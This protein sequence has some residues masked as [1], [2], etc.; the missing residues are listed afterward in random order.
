VYYADFSVTSAVMAM[1]VYGADKEYIE[2]PTEYFYQVWSC[3][4][5]QIFSAS[6]LNNL[7][8]IP[9]YFCR[10]S[11]IFSDDEEDNERY[12]YYS[13]LFSDMVYSSEEVWSENDDAMR[14]G[15]TVVAVFAATYAGEFDL[16]PR[17]V[18]SKLIKSAGVYYPSM[19]KLLRRL[20]SE[21]KGRLK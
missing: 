5:A 16:S 4:R 8:E 6:E 17:E 3:L 19:K 14:L 2:K 7:V 10:F 11:Y 21:A 12:Y 15:A 18:L 13:D 20:E 1:H 9:S